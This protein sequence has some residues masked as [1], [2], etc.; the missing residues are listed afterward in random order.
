MCLNDSQ[1]EIAVAEVATGA[2]T[3]V[4]VASEGEEAWS[5]RWSPDGTRLVFERDP[6]DGANVTG[7]EIVVIPAAGGDVTVVAPAEMFAGYPDWR[8]NGDLIVF[9]TY[10][11]S[12]FETSA[13]GATNLHTVAPDGSQLKQLT[14]NELGGDRDSQPSFTP[15]GERIIFTHTT[16]G[17][18]GYG[19]RR[20]AFVD[21]DGTGLTV[22]NTVNATHLRLQPGG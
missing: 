20:A 22:V 13:P 17:N 10:G 21:L 2:M 7:G 6:N 1:T 11:I 5:P 15:D 4:Y 14:T 16:N 18:T 12:V 3:S 9:E 8:P 19:V